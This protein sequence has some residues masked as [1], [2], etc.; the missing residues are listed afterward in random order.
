MC[1]QDEIELIVDGKTFLLG[2]G[3][4]FVFKSDLPHHYRN[5][6]DERASIFWVNT[7]ATF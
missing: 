1:L 3:D 7:P 5:I 2:A 4:T 6:G